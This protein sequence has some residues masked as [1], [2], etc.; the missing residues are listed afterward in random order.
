[1]AGLAHP[2]MIASLQPATCA[3]MLK[4][5]R[6]KLRRVVAAQPELFPHGLLHLCTQ[7]INC[8]HPPHGPLPAPADAAQRESGLC[9]CARVHHVHD[10]QRR[11]LQFAEISRS[12]QAFFE[13]SNV[14][15]AFDG[16]GSRGE[17]IS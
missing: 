5:R 7:G 6:K 8:V 13:N 17:I 9:S 14:L 16:L 4:H 10:D 1:M 11:Q 15:D 3:T 2:T 12:L